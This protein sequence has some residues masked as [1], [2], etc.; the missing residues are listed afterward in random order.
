MSP[1]LRAALETARAVRFLCSGN[2]VRSPFAELYARHLGC[3]V[4]VDSAATRFHNTSMFAQTRQALVEIGVARGELDAFVPRHLFEASAPAAE[5]CVVFGMTPD[6][7]Q[8]W[9]ATT[10][11]PT[12]TF[13]LNE[14]IGHASGISDP[15]L[16]DTPFDEAFRA[17]AACVESL[18]LHLLARSPGAGGF[19]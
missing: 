16:D 4:P 3:P 18:V 17:V 9:A 15:V 14:L 13:L 5:P 12:D 8:A 11:L 10:S 7:L 1:R 19:R 2:A 6:H